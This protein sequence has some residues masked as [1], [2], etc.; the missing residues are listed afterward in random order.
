M[1]KYLCLHYHR[2][3]KL[4]LRTNKVYFQTSQTSTAQKTF[5]EFSA[6]VRSVLK[7]FG[8][9]MFCKLNWS[10]P[11]D[12]VWIGLNKS[13]KCTNISQMYLL[14]KSSDFVTHDLTMPFKHC[15]DY[16]E[17]TENT[18]E[19]KIK[20]CLVLRE[21]MDINPGIGMYLII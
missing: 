17:Q 18:E 21:W 15:E 14:L 19:N 11:Q 1:T 7:E 13:L 4:Q 3:L 2:Y 6:Q 16:N 9:Q 20:Y 8:G 10:S 5:P 12:A